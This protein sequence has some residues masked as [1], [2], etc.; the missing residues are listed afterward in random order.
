MSAIFARFQFFAAVRRRRET[1][2]LLFAPSILTHLPNYFSLRAQWQWI[3]ETNTEKNDGKRKRIIYNTG[4]RDDNFIQWRYNLVRIEQKQLIWIKKT[5]FK[6]YLRKIES[7]CCGTTS[8]HLWHKNVRK[9]YKNN[10]F[11]C[12]VVWKLLYWPLL[13]YRNIQTP[14]YWS[15]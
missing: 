15:N 14:I 6:A 5:S 7:K 12:T 11:F 8:F 3:L 10:F 2:V 9:R 13:R 4:L 1:L